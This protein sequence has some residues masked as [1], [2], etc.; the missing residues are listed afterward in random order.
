MTSLSIQSVG[1]L[2]LLNLF[3][4][5]LNLTETLK[6]FPQ[7]LLTIC[8]ASIYSSVIFKILTAW[9]SFL[10]FEIRP[11]SLTSTE[12]T[13]P[14]G[15][16]SIAGVTSTISLHSLRPKRQPHCVEI[17]AKVKTVCCGCF[18]RRL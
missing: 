17:R 7:M 14:F 2:T 4:L 15:F 16:V 6:H 1:T 5:V 8:F 3:L 9:A 13:V 18:L 12:L 11:P 10:F